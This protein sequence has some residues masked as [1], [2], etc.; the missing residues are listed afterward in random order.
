M[1]QSIGNPLYGLKG[2]LDI[3]RS[4]H[5]GWYVVGI[6]DKVSGIAYYKDR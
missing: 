6:I 3:F 4:I 2:I 5:P 1:S